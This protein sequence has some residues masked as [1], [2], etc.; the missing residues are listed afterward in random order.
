VSAP[1]SSRPPTR[2]L[3]VLDHSLP[4]GSG[5]SYRSQSIVH[6]QQQLGL[7][8]VLLTSP[9][10]GSKRDQC[11]IMNG[12]RHYRTGNA[13]GR[14][15][16]VRE[17]RLMLKLAARIARVAKG[18]NIDLI[19]AH[20]P[21]LN[22]LPALLA[23]RRL[24][25]P[26]VYEVRTFWEDAAV[27]HSTFAEG[28][29][30]YR[31]SRALET[32]VLRRA[33][34]IVAICEGIRAEVASRGIDP[35]R[36]S[37]IPNGVDARWLEP[38]PSATE[39][40][41][42]L[43]LGTGPVFGYIGSFSHYEGLP[44]LVRAAPQFLGHFPGAK[45]LLV[46]S[47]RDDNQLRAT[48]GRTA[49]DIILTGRIPQEQVRDLYTLLDVLVLPR[50][51]MRLTE[52]VTPLKPLEAMAT[53]TAVLASDVGGHAE[54]VQ[55]GETGLLFKAESRDSLVEQ[56]VRLVEDF[57]LRRRLTNSARRWVASERTW[58]RIVEGYRLVYRTA[59][60]NTN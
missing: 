11:E 7:E 43:G 56:A 46:G 21:L 2:I 18:E 58:D 9:K 34:A 29:L 41:A 6:A 5:Y 16:F 53:G 48:A 44:F 59:R 24:G 60:E 14:L 3:H 19:H 10:H 30:R 42:S 35:Q 40:A 49:S 23:G 39:L 25:L 37:V 36:I 38:R 33:N 15:P 8:P 55:D 12:I 50:R 32:A 13:G 31:I 28:S 22:G 1:R 57:E 52:L 45:L 20:S 27:S 51:R 4:I 17:V 26:V 54:L 47:G